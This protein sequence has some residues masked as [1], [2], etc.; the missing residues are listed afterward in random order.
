MV[1]PGACV[2][3]LAFI[4]NC[5]QK[6]LDKIWWIC[7]NMNNALWRKIKMIEEDISHG[8]SNTGRNE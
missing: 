5:V 4:V 7:Y 8:R 1:S 2:I 6:A 3:F